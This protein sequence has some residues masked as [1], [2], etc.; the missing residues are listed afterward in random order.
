MT[1]FKKQGKY[2]RGSVRPVTRHFVGIK[3]NGA[4]LLVL[5][6]SVGASLLSQGVSA[7]K[8][9]WHNLD[10]KTD[11]VFGISTERAYQE[12]LGHKKATT[13]LVAVIDGGVDTAHED[14]KSVIWI[15][16]KERPGNGKDDDRNGYVDDLHGWDFIGGPT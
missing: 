12:L 10:L 6:L 9:N 11:S 14:L 1:H 15:N 2:P 3:R 13:V 16:P 5:F 7:Q 8:A 4:I